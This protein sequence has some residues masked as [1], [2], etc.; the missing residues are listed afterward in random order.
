[1]FDLASINTIE[2]KDGKLCLL[3]QR[4]L[5]KLFSIFECQNYRDVEFA[6]KDMVVRGAPAIGVAGA[7]GLV[8]AA[9]EFIEL[10]KEEFLEQISC[11][12]TERKRQCNWQFSPNSRKFNVGC[13]THG[14]DY[15]RE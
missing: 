11:S 10:P 8:L 7:Y 6:I 4:K 1:L 3:D 2:F 13:Q 15:R 9:S 12:R 14:S 5:P